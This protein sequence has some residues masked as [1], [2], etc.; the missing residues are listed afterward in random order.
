MILQTQ[1]R[2]N[3]LTLSL[4]KDYNIPNVSGK[5]LRIIHSYV[6]YINRVVWKK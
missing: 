2:A 5:I 6:D 4:A 1:S 3:D